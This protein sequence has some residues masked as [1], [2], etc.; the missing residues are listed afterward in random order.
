MD[1]SARLFIREGSLQ[2]KRLNRL[3]IHLNLKHDN[4]VF[5]NMDE[6]KVKKN[7]STLKRDSF[8]SSYYG[9]PYA[10]DWYNSEFEDLDWRRR[11]TG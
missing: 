9:D 10:Y 4:H 6:E 1:F 5:K 7:D 8:N 3:L 11:W 2:M